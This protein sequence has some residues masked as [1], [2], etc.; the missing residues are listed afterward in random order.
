[1]T[2]TSKKDKN[3]MQKPKFVPWVILLTALMSIATTSTV[4]T[5]FY[6]EKSVTNVGTAICSPIGSQN[7][8]VNDLDFNTPTTFTGHL[9]TSDSPPQIAG[10]ITFTFT[11]QGS[12][13]PYSLKS[14]TFSSTHTSATSNVFGLQI[15]LS[16]GSASAPGLNRFDVTATELGGQQA[17][18]FFFNTTGSRDILGG[19]WLIKDS[20]GQYDGFFGRWLVTANGSQDVSSPPTS[21]PHIW[22]SKVI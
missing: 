22:R 18:I 7:T 15:F 14:V 1:M 5:I 6:S 10:D 11:T 19:V 20:G 17:T 8:S 21:T 9:L 12:S 4:M 3:I 2:P 13:P 16:N